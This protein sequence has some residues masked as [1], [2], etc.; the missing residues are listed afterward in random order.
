MPRGGACRWP[1]GCT[2]GV[3]GWR[4]PRLVVDQSVHQRPAA[5]GVLTTTLSTPGVFLPALTCVTRRTLMRHVGVATQ[6]ELLE[7]AHLAVVARLGRPE[8][9]LSQIADDR[10]LACRQSTASQSVSSLGSVCRAAPAS[11]LSLGWHPSRRTSGGSPDPRQQP[12]GSGQLALS[13]GLWI[14][15][16]LS[17]C[18][19]RFLDLPVP[20]GVLRRPLRSAYCRRRGRPHRGCH[21]PHAGDAVGVG[22]FLTPGSRCPQPGQAR[23]GSLCAQ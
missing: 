10:R 13:A 14:S 8:D 15:P 16:C 18:G 4:S 7:R 21:V 17:A 12:F 3:T 20:A 22:A 2:R 9:A 5:S 1:S 19:L 23:P 11:N 6:H